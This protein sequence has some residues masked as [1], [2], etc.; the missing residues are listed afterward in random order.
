AV[1][2]E[3]AGSV[4]EAQAIAVEAALELSQELLNGGAPGLHL[5]GLNKSEIVLRLVDQLNLL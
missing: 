5:Y 3:G 1:R 2:V 4:D